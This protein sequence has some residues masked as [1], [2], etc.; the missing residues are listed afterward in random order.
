[1][2]EHITH[3]EAAKIAQKLPQNATLKQ[4]VEAW[5]TVKKT[6]VSARVFE[7]HLMMAN[8]LLERLGATRRPREIRPL[9]L[10]Q[11][12]AELAQKC[13]PKTV[14]HYVSVARGIFDEALIDEAIE[15][16]PVIHVQIPRKKISLEELADPFSVEEIE[17]IL[18]ASSPP[19]RRIV[20][21]MV[22]TGLRSGELLAL[23]WSD[24][25]F[26]RGEIA[27]RRSRGGGKDGPTKT[28]GSKRVIPLWPAVKPY[29]CELLEETGGEGYL[30]RTAYGEPW[31]ES[32][33]INKKHWAPLLKKLGIRYRRLYQLRHTWASHMLLNG[34]YPPVQIARWM[35]HNSVEMLFRRYGRYVQAH[36]PKIEESFSLFG[37]QAGKT[38]RRK[39]AN[40]PKIKKVG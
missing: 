15:K 17:T 2:V 14:G 13:S 26:E 10:R 40:G 24:V 1:M 36:K 28:I 38:P 30:F 35:G 12:V 20:G 22:N 32:Q 3:G 25:D 21:V 18:K 23:R 34:H 7:S 4:Y 31:Y 29:L 11:W 8:R 9:E 16:N 37:K 5:L 6:T 19:L 39:P 27:I 33:T